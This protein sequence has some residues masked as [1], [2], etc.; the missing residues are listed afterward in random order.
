MASAFMQGF[1]PLHKNPFALCA[2]LII[3]IV[4]AGVGVPL[5]SLPASLLL[6]QMRCSRVMP[7]TVNPASLRPP[8][9]RGPWC[10]LT[11]RSSIRC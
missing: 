10:L 6:T 7:R 8:R 3:L 2:T 11:Q 9:G 1:I 4:A 5:L